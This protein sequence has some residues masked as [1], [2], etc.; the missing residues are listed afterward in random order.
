MEAGI[1]VA[2]FFY[3]KKE[4][5]IVFNSKGFRGQEFDLEKKVDVVR[6]ITMGDS[7]TFGIT[8]ESCPYPAQLQGLLNKKFPNKLEVINVGV[9][10]YSSE[11]VLNRFKYD[12]IQY[13]PDIV[14]IYVGWN[15]LYSINP[16]S[17]SGYKKFN[18][19]AKF[20]NNFYLYKAARKVIFL[21][22]KPRVDNIFRKDSANHLLETYYQDFEP[23]IYKENLKETIEIAE[24]NETK[25]ILVNLA[26][27]LYDE[28]SEEDIKK[29]HYPYF[30]SDIE[31]LKLLQEIYNDA[32]QEVALE[33]NIPLIDINSAINQVPDKGKLFF[34][35][36]HPYCEGQKIIAEIIFNNLINQKLLN[37]V[38]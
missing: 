28:M 19:I 16:A 30:T 12:I 38:E 9:E 22:I 7:V 14:T 36:M 20:L 33:M 25:I 2:L 32:I 24:I 15:D 13:N 10:G 11:N 23:I 1:R 4:E 26:S 5:G 18:N 3:L 29:V 6:I 35:T 37:F 17:S 31:K 27:V 8:P 34:D 21:E